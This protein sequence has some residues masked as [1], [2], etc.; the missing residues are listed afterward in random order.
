MNIQP[1]NPFAF[2]PDF[3]KSVILEI[4]KPQNLSRKR[5]A[6]DSDQIKN[7]A[8]KPYVKKRL[9]QMYPKTHSM[10]TV[11]DYSV[12]KKIV[13][14]KAKAYK[15]APIR[16]LSGDENKNANQIYQTIV[17]RYG[18]NQA[19]KGLDESFNQ[20]KHGLLA[21]FM[22]R[23]PL[24]TQ[25]QPMLS[26]KFF[27]LAPYEYDVVK[28]ADGKVRV[29][30][31]SYP[32]KSVTPA[33][34]GDGYNAIISEA[35]KGDESKQERLYAFW[36]D[37]EYV[38]VIVN[39]GKG[40]NNVNVQVRVT[41]SLGKNPYG[42][43]PFVYV[44]MDYDM[45]YPNL[46]PLPMQTVEFN[47]LF[48]VYLTSANM[49]VGILKITRPESQKLS[50]ASQSMYTAIEVP[51]SSD[52]ED[53]PSDINFIAPT[54][55][56]EGHKSAITTYLTTLLDEQGI[57][58]NAVVNP[59]EDF[60]SGL[61]RL[62]AQADVQSIIEENQELYLKAEQQVYRI[63][64]RQLASQ[65][66]D[67]LPPEEK[68]QIIYRKPKVMISDKEKLE[69]LKV[70]KELDLWPEYEL[71]MQYD[72]NLSADEAKKKL[73]EI[74]QAKADAAARNADP[75]KVF[76]GA[77]VAAIVDVSVRVGTGELTYDAGVAILVASFAIPEEKAKEMVPK[78]GSIK[79]KVE[80]NNFAKPSFPPK[81]EEV[82]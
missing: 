10:Y 9:E 51:Q 43:L 59:S 1:N 40:T 34:G 57:N 70:M 22:D 42:I 30:I 28:D 65:Q 68:F 67:T 79:P 38:E 64:K 69:N 2:T 15:E 7:G 62:L 13:D 58:G 49:Q 56:M 66:Q 25:A 33:E 71:I 74:E 44:P 14:K 29:V 75:T 36:S 19:M 26:W 50:I 41:E 3:I 47:A 60:S 48:S 37:E 35:G 52:P 80:V 61:D 24:A 73:I 81:K 63:I 20:H 17:D 21:C 11:T 55:N 53:K 45:N 82:K 54:P 31:L 16:K 46:S 76:N 39:G 5:T 18:L 4:E 8:L 23:A 12:M 72:P 32:A 77:Q 78:E 27:S 6:W